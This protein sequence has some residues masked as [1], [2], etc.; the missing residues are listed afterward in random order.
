MRK[1]KGEIG[2]N[3]AIHTSKTQPVHIELM[4]S[5]ISVCDKLIVFAIKKHCPSA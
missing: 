2:G 1:G 5:T 3:L 4:M